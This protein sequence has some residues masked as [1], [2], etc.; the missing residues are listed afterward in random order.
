[1]WE[2][3]AFVRCFAGLWLTA[4]FDGVLLGIVL[5]PWISLLF[6]WSALPPHDPFW[7]S[8]WVRSRELL[9]LTLTLAA[10]ALMI[11]GFIKMRLVECDG[12]I[13]PAVAK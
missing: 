3:K 12:G 1:V 2:R 7:D 6:G 13:V 8:W 4:V 10:F 5:A 9:F 11:S